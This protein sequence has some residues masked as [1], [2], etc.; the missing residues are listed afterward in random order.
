[1]GSGDVYGSAHD[2]RYFNKIKEDMEAD[3]RV[4]YANLTVQQGTTGFTRQ[5]IKAS[6]KYTIYIGSLGQNRVNA[7]TFNGVDVTDQVANGY[8]TTPEIKGESVLSVS[9]ETTTSARALTLENV[10]VTG[11]NGEITI[12][13][14]D[15]PSDISVYTVDGKLIKSI[16]E[17]FG[18]ANLQ[19]PAEQLYIVKVG[20]RTYKVAL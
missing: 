2:W 17:A 10:K 8:Y 20:S 9:Y 4:Y 13:H 14:I 1:M 11:Y 18:S 5:A 12:Q 7:V 16:P 6:E 3:G 15:E 19:V